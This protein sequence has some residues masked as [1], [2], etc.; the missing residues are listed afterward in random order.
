MIFRIKIRLL[1]ARIALAS[2]C[3]CLAGC[4][5]LSSFRVDTDTI[6]TQRYVSS[7]DIQVEVDS[8]VKPL[9]ES[10]HTPGLVLG[11]LLSDGQTRFFSYGIA[12]KETNQAVNPDTLFNIGSLSKG[13]LGLITAQL[14]EEGVFA[15]D[16]TLAEALPHDT[17]SALTQR[18]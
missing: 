13:F 14:V 3:L 4:G 7:N 9:I 18:K 15:W 5:T 12:D 16:T 17:P 2:V 8:L 6:E 11:V 1:H 10:K